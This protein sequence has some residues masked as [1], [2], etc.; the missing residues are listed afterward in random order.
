MIISEKY[1]FILF[2]LYYFNSNLIQ[3]VRLVL[4]LGTDY[5]IKRKASCLIWSDDPRL[6]T[7]HANLKYRRLFNLY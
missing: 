7:Q 1:I 3:R 2:L 5:Q 6:V 4:L